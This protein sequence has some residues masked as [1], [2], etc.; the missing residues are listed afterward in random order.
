MTATVGLISGVMILKRM[1]R[2]PAP[3]SCVDS[4]RLSGTPV[5]A[6]RTMTRLNT[7][8]SEGRISDHVELYNPTLL[9]TRKK[10]IMPP[11]KYML[12]TTIRL[13]ARLSM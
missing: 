8:M 11:E 1:V 9:T 4:S 6:V 12:K 13:N 10:G 7:L 2:W 3:S 5:M